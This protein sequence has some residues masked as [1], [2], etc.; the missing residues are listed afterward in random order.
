MLILGLIEIEKH[1]EQEIRLRNNQ[2]NSGQLNQLRIINKTLCIGYCDGKR[3]QEKAL[4]IFG[5][6]K[7]KR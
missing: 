1:W 2:T 6:Y 4:F 7:Y 5:Q 3:V